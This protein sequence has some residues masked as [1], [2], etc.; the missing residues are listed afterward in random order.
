[1]VK[2]RLIVGKTNQTEVMEIFGPPDHVTKSGKGEM[3]G[4]DKVSRE[5]AVAATGARADA[6]AGARAGG[7]V[8][9]GG[10]VLP[11]IGGAGGGVIGGALGGVGAGVGSEV[12]QATSQST[13]QAAQQAQ[14]IETTKTVFLLV[15]FNEEGIVKDYKLSATK[16]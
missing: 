15:Y 2:T 7:S 3:W 5:V 14:Q 1:M 16:F 8:G 9:L 10:G 4:Y 12:G 6:A 11:F 13:A